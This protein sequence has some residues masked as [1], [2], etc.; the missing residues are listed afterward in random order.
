MLTLDNITLSRNNSIIVKDFGLTIFANTCVT[1]RGRNGSGKTTL[2][3]CI[4]GIKKPDAG[5]IIYDDDS[6]VIHVGHKNALTPELSVYDN[7]KYWADLNLMSDAI[8]IS[9]MVFG[10]NSYLDVKVNELSQGWKKKTAL[11][12]LLLSPADIWCLDEPYVNLDSESAGI[13]D[14][15]IMAKCT[16]GGIVIIASNE[17]VTAGSDSISQTKQWDERRGDATIFSNEN[18]YNISIDVEELR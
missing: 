11:T 9:T 14:N 2:L 1:I 10:L 8:P 15:M 13:L 17:D 4:V 16:Q 6:Q 5:R 7:L 18:G 12:R 3:N